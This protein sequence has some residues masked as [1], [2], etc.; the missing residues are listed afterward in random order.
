MLVDVHA[1]L[2]DKAFE[3]DIDEVIQRAEKAGVKKIIT[4]GVHHESNLKVLELAKKYKIVEAA[5]GMY[6][7]NCLNVKI[8]PEF[9][10]YNKETKIEL[11]ETLKFI[12]KNK[13]KIVAIGEVGIDYKYSDDKK[14]Q[15]EN[16]QKIIDLSKKIK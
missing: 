6:P 4:Q 13:D 1:H 7:I 16:F 8:K 3:N 15:I 10:T 14:P 9:K 12:Q 11:D 5:L 2:D